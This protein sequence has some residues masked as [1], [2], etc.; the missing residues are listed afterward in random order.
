MR[1]DPEIVK[2]HQEVLETCRDN[3]MHSR[4]YAIVKA[5]A[6]I[7][8]NLDHN[9]PLDQNREALRT[10]VKQMKATVDEIMKYVDGLG[11]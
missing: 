2:K 3:I 10:A 9:E 5:L 11:E 4:E 1:R 7:G 6:D 8:I